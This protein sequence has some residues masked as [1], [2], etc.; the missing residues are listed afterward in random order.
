MAIALLGF[1]VWGHHMFTSGQSPV[2]SIV[3]SLITFLIGIPSGIKVF[4]W[5]WTMYNGS[6][7]L[8]TPMLY[9]LTFLFQ[10][11]IGGVTGVMVGALSVDIHLH[12]TYYV[13][14]HFHYVLVPGAIFSI[15]AAVYYWL[16]KW[17]GNMYNETMGRWHFWLSFIGVNVTFFPM[18]FVGLAGMPRRIPG[19]PLQFADFNAVASVGAF[20]FGLSQLLLVYNVIQC[21]RVKRPATPEVWEGA[22]GLEWTVPSPAPYHT[23]AQPPLVK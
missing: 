5:V 23:F 19:Y 15:V 21:I 9:A 1:L 12:D 18:H 4:N 14:A 2:S 7:W 22:E 20:M 6:V 13:V 3:F 16:P 8:T 11:T 17:T 10:F